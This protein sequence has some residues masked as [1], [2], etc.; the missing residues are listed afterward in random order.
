MVTIELIEQLHDFGTE[1]RSKLRVSFLLGLLFDAGHGGCILRKNVSWFL[2]PWNVA[3]ISWDYNVLYPRRQNSSQ[4]LLGESEIL[5]QFI[6]HINS[7]NENNSCKVW[8]VTARVIRSTGLRHRGLLWKIRINMLPPSSGYEHVGSGTDLVGEAGYNGGD[9]RTKNQGVKKGT[10]SEQI[11][12]N[13]I[14]K[15]HSGFFIDRRST[16]VF[17]GKVQLYE[18]C[19][20]T[21]VFTVTVPLSHRRN[22]WTENRKNVDPDEKRGLHHIQTDGG[23]KFFRKFCNH[24]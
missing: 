11:G 4:S 9:H 5:L 19:I 6:L 2:Y 7:E 12:K 18:K 15:T 24:P 8:F 23:N 13:Y 20:K 22:V 10:N 17:K 1:A 16:V 3:W 21:A 14:S